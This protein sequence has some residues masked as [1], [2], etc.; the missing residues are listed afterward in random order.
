MCK[1]ITEIYNNKRE[2]NLFADI[3]R[4]I[5]CY[6]SANLIVSISCIVNG[7]RM[8][9]CCHFKREGGVIESSIENSRGE[10][11]LIFGGKECQIYII[12]MFGNEK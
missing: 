11:L 5:A 12:K 2:Q 3:N 10:K 8:A 4:S 1:V 9:D 7:S 6:I